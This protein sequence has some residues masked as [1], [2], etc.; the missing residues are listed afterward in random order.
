MSI[1]RMKMAG[2][3]ATAWFRTLIFAA[4][5]RPVAQTRNEEPP[6]R[7]CGFLLS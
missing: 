7:V 6:W 4:E 3:V 5:N 2:I 1:K